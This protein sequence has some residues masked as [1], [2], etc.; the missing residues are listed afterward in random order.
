MLREIAEEFGGVSISMPR[1]PNSSVVTLKGAADCV[2]GAKKRMLEIAD[3]LESMI[4]IECEILQKH[5]RAVMGTRGRNVQ[6]ITARNNVQIKFPERSVPNGNVD[7]NA[8]NGDVSP[9]PASDIILITGKQENA[10][11]AKMELLVRYYESLV[12][13]VYTLLHL[14]FP[15]VSPFYVVSIALSHVELV[16]D[17]NPEFNCAVYLL[18]PAI[19]KMLCLFEHF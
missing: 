10:E 2:E 19:F 5:H 9:R 16:G 7:E 11:K 18:F 17:V 13:P 12:F 1:E 4:T 15:Y 6:E 14:S 8:E 3:D